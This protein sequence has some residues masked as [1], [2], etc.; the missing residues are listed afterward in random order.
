MYAKCYT[1][2]KLKRNCTKIINMF[3]N[4]LRS[5][6]GFEHDPSDLLLTISLFYWGGV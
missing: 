5:S 6:D 2:Q 4:E 3:R 1:P